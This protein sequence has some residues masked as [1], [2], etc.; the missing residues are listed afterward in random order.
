MLRLITPS[1]VSLCPPDKQKHESFCSLGVK[2]AKWN[3]WNKC[4]SSVKHNN[5]AGIKVTC[6]YLDILSSMCFPA[7][8]MMAAMLLL[9]TRTAVCRCRLW[10]FNLFNLP[11][12]LTVTM[13]T[14]ETTKRETMQE[15]ILV[16]F[17]FP[18]F[19]SFSPAGNTQLTETV[20]EQHQLESLII[21][22]SH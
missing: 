10:W 6:S 19:F 15:L 21:Q 8:P 20:S 11:P 17:A 3:K 22:C 1:S 13:E 4:V 12:R 9:W 7:V 14:T 5:T 16:V 2:Q 18:A